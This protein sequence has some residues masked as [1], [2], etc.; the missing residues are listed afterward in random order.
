MQNT[1][2]QKLQAP[3][4][5]ICIGAANLDIRG[6]FEHHSVDGTSNPAS[7]SQSVGGAALNTARILAA[8]NTPTRFIG[9]VGDD[10]SAQSIADALK[11]ANVENGLIKHKTAASGRYISLLEPDGTLKTACN[12]MKIHENFSIE[13]LEKQLR[14]IDLSKISAV[15]CDANLPANIV[16]RAFELHP[17]SLKC[18]TTVSP[19]KAF[20][21]EKS[22]NLIDI[23]FTN[24]TE[25]TA[26]LK[27]PAKT[28]S[29]NLAGMMLATPV[30]SGIISNGREPLYY[31]Q[32]GKAYSIPIPPID[33]I[34]DV[35]GAGDALAAGTLAAM[36]KGESLSDAIQQGIYTAQ[37]VLRV[38]GAH[39]S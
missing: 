19:A 30:K 17:Q 21:L 15:F 2:S 20:R 11:L 33:K 5:A 4:R 39:L 3:K 36:L 16:K 35:V 12:D 26:L 38:P 7:I 32:N 28:S 13:L 34:V 9:L 10:N 1:K 14:L 31:W 27:A 22:F 8:S 29:E 18:A 25:A 23:L 37:K 6:A 24:V